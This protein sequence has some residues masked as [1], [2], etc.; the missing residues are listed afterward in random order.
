MVFCAAHIGQGGCNTDGMAPATRKAL[1]SAADPSTTWGIAVLAAVLI[2]VVLAV[3][4]MAVQWS[5][6]GL[7]PPSMASVRE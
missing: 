4:G 3:L 6:D 2:L 7:R 1:T 5:G